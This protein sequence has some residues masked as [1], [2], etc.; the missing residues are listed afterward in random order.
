MHKTIGLEFT[1]LIAKQ[2]HNWDRKY[3]WCHIISILE[4]EFD[5]YE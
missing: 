3:E 5:K 2:Q 4:P 1:R